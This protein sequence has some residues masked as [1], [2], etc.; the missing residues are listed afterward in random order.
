MKWN[1][2]IKP[3]Q[4]MFKVSDQY[5]DQLHKEITNSPKTV[6]SKV[7]ALNK[8]TAAYAASI[9]AAVLIVITFMFSFPENQ[10]NHPASEAFAFQTQLSGDDLYQIMLEDDE[11][12]P[13]SDE[14]IEY[15]V[16]Y[17]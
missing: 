10:T 5:F 3:K 15:A 6:S 7:I 9:A 16:L 14:L 8:K 11:L 1:E 2:N 17:Y 12:Q 13:S 4:E